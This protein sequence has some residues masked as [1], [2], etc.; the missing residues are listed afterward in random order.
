MIGETFEYLY[1]F[2]LHIGFNVDKTNGC[3]WQALGNHHI[4]IKDDWQS[5]VNES[6]TVI[7]GD[8]SWELILKSRVLI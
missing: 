6:D 1:N 2:D 3:V 7:A 5:R 4:K 8:I